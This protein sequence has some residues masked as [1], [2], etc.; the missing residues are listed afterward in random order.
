MTFEQKEMDLIKGVDTPKNRQQ[1][2]VILAIELFK[3]NNPN[4]DMSSH[5]VR[6]ET[7]FE[8]SKGGDAS[9]SAAYRGVENHPDFSNHPRL[10]GLSTNITLEDVDYFL[11]EKKLK[12]N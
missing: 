11:R 8:W 9:Y 2:Q 12:D 1:Q 7:M 10:K 3:K 4:A 5:E 6:N